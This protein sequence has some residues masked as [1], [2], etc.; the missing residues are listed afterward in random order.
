MIPVGTACCDT[1]DCDRGDCLQLTPRE[2]VVCS[3]VCHSET[4]LS[5][6]RIKERCGLHQE[7][8]SRILRRLSVY[9]ALEKV[10]GKYRRR[11]VNK[12]LEDK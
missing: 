10:D 9:G 6:S 11:L 4:P 3:T 5:F 12:N 2:E 1:L 8:L 7:V